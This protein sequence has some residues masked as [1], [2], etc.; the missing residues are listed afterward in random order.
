MVD[1]GLSTPNKNALAPS[2]NFCSSTASII[3]LGSSF[4]NLVAAGL[5]DLE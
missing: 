2:L 1:Y 4:H 5:K 3:M